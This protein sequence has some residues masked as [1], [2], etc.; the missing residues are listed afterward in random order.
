MHLFLP[1]FG[2]LTGRVITHTQYMYNVWAESM[3]WL[4]VVYYST[5]Q[6][7]RRGVMGI[8]HLLGLKTENAEVNCIHCLCIPPCGPHSVCN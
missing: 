3:L 8:L 1:M 6:F 4:H 2:E 7:R 5:L